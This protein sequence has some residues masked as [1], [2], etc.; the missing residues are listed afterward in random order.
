M[1]V[2]RAGARARAWAQAGPPTATSWP[3]WPS[4][5][6]FGQPN[7]VGNF[8]SVPLQRRGVSRTSQHKRPD[9]ITSPVLTL[10]CP[11]TAFPKRMRLKCWH[12]YTPLRRGLHV[13][14]G[15][16][17]MARL[18]PALRPGPLPGP[19]GAQRPFARS[20]CYLSQGG[21]E[22]HLGGR[23][24]SFVAHTTSCARP[25]PSRRLR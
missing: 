20:R 9:N 5:R 24:P 15:P 13:G 8:G 3:P 12:T 17:L 11:P 4:W 25:N 21:V 23:Y 6:P 1:C 10:A 16:S 18:L 22:H 7:Y 14:L 2:H 19:P